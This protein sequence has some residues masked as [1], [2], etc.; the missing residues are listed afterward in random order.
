MSLL[1]R[2]G[3]FASGLVLILLGRSQLQAGHWVFTNASYHQ[4]TFAA[5]GIG[6]GCLICFVSFLPSGDWVYKRIT[7]GR[8]IKKVSSKRRFGERQR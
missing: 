7:T 1:I 3:L 6:L 2:L 4:T 8:K 5:S